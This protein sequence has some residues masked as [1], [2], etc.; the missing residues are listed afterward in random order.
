MDV[1]KQSKQQRVYG[2]L[3]GLIEAKSSKLGDLLPSEQELAGRLEVN[4][5]TVAK[6]MSVLASE[7]YVTRNRRA[8]TAI[9]RKP[10]AAVRDTIAVF[11][12]FPSLGIS[13]TFDYYL[14]L[15]KGIQYECLSRGLKTLSVSCRRAGGQPDL[16][17]LEGVCSLSSLKGLVIADSYI[18]DQPGMLAAIDGK[19]VP[20]VWVASG[21][22]DGKKR[23][24][25]DVDDERVSWELARAL[26]AAGCKRPAFMAPTLDTVARRRRLAG[27]KRALAE[28]GLPLQEGLV[29]ASDGS[30][31][32]KESGRECAGLCLARKLKPDGLLFS[33]FQLLDGAFELWSECGVEA[34]LKIPCAAFDCG[35]DY[36]PSLA[37]SAVQP[38]REIGSE[39]VRTLVAGSPAP[40]QRFIP[41]E[42][43]R[44]RRVDK[45]AV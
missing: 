30:L 24:L 4:R 9:A 31:P 1:K 3:M 16:A 17:E 23:N 22:L 35:V 36:H 42:I 19:D 37:A 34:L 6:A 40:S 27:F 41:V 15:M 43:Q 2:Y 11:A 39:A 45:E 20:V 29:I 5:M 33:D 38:I 14:E 28:A 44:A 25:I 7:G 18:G 21:E 12:P 32:I 8:G 26:V 10:G 13:L